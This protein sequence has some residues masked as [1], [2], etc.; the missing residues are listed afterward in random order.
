MLYHGGEIIPDI[1]EKQPIK[2]AIKKKATTPPKE[3][4]HRG[5]RQLQQ[6]VKDAARH[7]LNSSEESQQSNPEVSAHIRR[8]MTRRIAKRIHG[9]KERT[10]ARQEQ[11]RS[12]EHLRRS[13]QK[14]PF[15][16]PNVTER[17]R[18]LAKEKA[19]WRTTEQNRTVV[20]QIATDKAPVRISEPPKTAER[21]LSQQTV[22]DK[23][24]PK[25]L[26]HRAIA[27]KV[28]TSGQ[29]QS[30]KCTERTVKTVKTPIKTTASAAPQKAARATTRVVH[31]A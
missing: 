3:L 27:P 2:G 22:T 9:P 26:D 23:I 20:R 5:A 31:K 28:K 21:S 11:P 16:E 8:N 12:K 7:G 18:E 4:A 13:E 14:E 17:G 25:T 15:T 29:V 1:K 19:V 30:I 24:V 6:E 10:A